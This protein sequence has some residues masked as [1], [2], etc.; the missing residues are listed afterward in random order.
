MLSAAIYG[1][2]ERR[3][4]VTCFLSCFLTLYSNPSFNAGDT[5]LLRGAFGESALDE[6]NLDFDFWRYENAAMESQSK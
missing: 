3:I 6:L 4:P 1:T 2:L 5:L